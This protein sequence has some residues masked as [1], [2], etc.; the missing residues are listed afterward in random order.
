MAFAPHRGPHG[1]DLA[2]D[3]L[4]RKP[5]SRNDGCDVIDSDTTGHPITPLAS[6]LVCSR[7]IPLE[8]SWAPYTPRR[9]RPYPTGTQRTPHRTAASGFVSK[10]ESRE[11]PSPVH[12]PRPSARSSDG[13][14]TPFGQPALVVGQADP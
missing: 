2:H 10:V 11:S 13:A 7:L 9:G 8:T 6:L 12:R 4:G 1:N 3:G 5:S 14:R